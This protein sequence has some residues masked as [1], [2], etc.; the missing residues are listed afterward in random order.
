[1]KMNAPK[2]RITAHL[3]GL[4]FL[5]ALFS[6]GCMGNQ[7]GLEVQPHDENTFMTIMHAM[8]EKMDA[9]PMTGDPDHDF[10]MMM[11]M[12]HQGAIDMAKENL[13]SGRNA[14]MRAMAEKMIQAQQREIAEFTAF[15]ST[16]VTQPQPNGKQF[17]MEQ[18]ES[19]HRMMMANDLRMITGN[20]DNDFAQ[21]MIDHHQ[22]A[23]ESS[24]SVIRY[25]KETM[26]K[27]IARKIMDDQR[28]EISALQEWLLKNKKH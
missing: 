1:M 12:H 19:M 23:I 10:A 15:L 6:T 13:K 8:M 28:M 5:L 26:T 25:G 21:L 24:E 16:Y 11:R 27:Q 2:T 14:E 20:A 22:S 18:K 17:M 9:V 7:Q 4:A 3:S